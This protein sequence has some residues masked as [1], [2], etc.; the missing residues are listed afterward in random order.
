[1]EPK[2]SCSKL[3]HNINLTRNEQ[4]FSCSFQNQ[5]TGQDA[6]YH[7]STSKDATKNLYSHIGDRYSSQ[8]FSIY[9]R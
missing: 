4:R 7:L 5:D 8:L 6:L 9:D 1:V 2:V 3:L